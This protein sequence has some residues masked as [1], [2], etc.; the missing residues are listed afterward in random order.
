MELGLFH[1]LNSL[2][3]LP[4]DFLSLLVEDLS[5]NF[6]GVDS[7]FEMEGLDLERDV[8]AG[9]LLEFLHPFGGIKEPVNFEEQLGDGGLR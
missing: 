9:L 1:G 3:K 6:E 2:L 5:T 4:V 8:V 7:V